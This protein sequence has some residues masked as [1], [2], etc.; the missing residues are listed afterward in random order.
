M[1]IQK[2]K[3]VIMPIHKVYLEKI[4]N[5]TK[6]YEIRKI[7][8]RPGTQY[9][10]FYQ[11][12]YGVITAKAT[13]NGQFR[14]DPW[15]IDN[16][17]WDKTGLSTEKLYKYSSDNDYTIKTLNVIKLLNPSRLVNPIQ[18]KDVGLKRA[19]QSF[20]YRDVSYDML[21]GEQEKI[22]REIL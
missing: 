4:L 12:K 18:I 7:D 20:V 9:I 6:T 19:P 21:L 8:I 16:T 13:F 1:S 2:I 10:L 14:R 11:I 3:C 5:G 17:I 22:Y 15:W